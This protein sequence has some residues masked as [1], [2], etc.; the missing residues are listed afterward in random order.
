MGD[1]GAL[2]RSRSYERARPAQEAGSGR[3]EHKDHIEERDEDS[4][5]PNA[6]RERAGEP[7][8]PPPK[9]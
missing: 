6:H 4:R 7:T 1:E 5:E 9:A 2:L 3:K 8:N